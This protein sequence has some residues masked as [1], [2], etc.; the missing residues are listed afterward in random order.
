MPPP[1]TNDSMISLP[2]MLLLLLWLIIEV[3]E[4]L[5]SKC[6]S[7][8]SYTI[9]VILLTCYFILCRS[10]RNRQRGRVEDVDVDD[11]MEGGYRNYFT[12][13]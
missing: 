11:G 10:D 3:T 4:A 6:T 13:E 8:N 9:I 7:Y 5:E 1:P 2:I 12:F